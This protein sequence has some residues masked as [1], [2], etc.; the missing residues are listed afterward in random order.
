MIPRWPRYDGCD[1]D[2]KRF[3][4]NW[5]AGSYKGATNSDHITYYIRPRRI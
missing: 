3:S 2:G 5:P 1:G 4:G